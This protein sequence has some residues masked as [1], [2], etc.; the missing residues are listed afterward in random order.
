MKRGQLDIV[1]TYSQLFSY[2]RFAHLESYNRD[3]LKISFLP[4]NK[5]DIFITSSFDED[6]GYLSF[7]I[8]FHLKIA[9]K[10]SD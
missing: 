3:D 10:A 8:N 2:I 6:R 1:D 5:F 7:I 9:K 4:E